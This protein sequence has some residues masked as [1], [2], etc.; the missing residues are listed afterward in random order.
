[1]IFSTIYLFALLFVV[2]IAVLAAW[3]DITNMVIDNLY[4]IMIVL[5]FA[6]AYGAMFA[7]GKQDI[8]FDDLWRHG[9]PAVIVLLATLIMFALGWIGAGDSKLATA[10]ALWL[11][12]PSGLIYF[13]FATTLA[14]GILAFATLLIGRFKPF[15]NPSA[16]SWIGCAQG[17]EN[18]VPYGAAIA[19]GFIVMLVQGGYFDLIKIGVIDSGRL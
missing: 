13:L 17:G 18:A 7:A 6:I 19:F 15:R 2:V 5:F 3:S 4:S 10:C 11:S 14:G 16:N 8:A 9:A 12:F 1:M